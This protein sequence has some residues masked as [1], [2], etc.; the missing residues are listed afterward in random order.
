M[1][2]ALD[3]AAG[4]VRRVL[5][6]A[7]RAQGRAV[8]QRA[9]VEMQD[10]DG[11]VRRDR[12]DLVEGRQA[13]LGELMLREA[14]D[15]AHPLRR[16]RAVDL[17][18]QHAHGVGERA[19]AV[20]AQLHVVVEAAADD[21]HVAV[22]Q[23]RDDAPPFEVD[24]AGLRPGELHDLMIAA[25][26]GEAP[27]ADG[28]GRGLGLLPVQ[29]R[30]LAVEENQIRRCIHCLCLRIIGKGEAARQGAE[31]AD[32]AAAV[33]CARHGRSPESRAINRGQFIME[34]QR[35]FPPRGR[36][37]GWECWRQ[38]FIGSLTPHLQ[39]LPSASRMSDCKDQDSLGQARGL[40]RR[41]SVAF[42]GNALRSHCGLDTPTGRHSAACA[43][44]PSL[45]PNMVLA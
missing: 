10:E 37:Q 20:P 7:D 29:G 33:R 44:P 17:L 25:D 38:T 14:A 13:L 3:L 30:N 18:F 21:V 42:R 9:V 19:H 6:V 41:A 40:R 43:C 31:P 22:D 39:L 23:A 32:D 45:A 11:R 16:G 35:F 8:Q 5:G 24:A 15:H 2:I 28:D 36:D 1:R 26:G 34:C 27:V 4:R 12:V